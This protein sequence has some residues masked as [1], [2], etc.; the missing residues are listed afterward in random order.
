MQNLTIKAQIRAGFVATLALMVALAL[1]AIYRV[2]IV[3]ANLEQINDVNSVKQRYAINFRGRVHDRAIALRDVVLVQTESELDAAIAEI[4]NLEQIYAE[5]AAPLDKMLAPDQNPTAD[6]LEILDAIKATEAETGP[7]INDVIA[8]HAQGNE[9][10]A[11]RLLLSE[12]RPSFDI[13]L[14]HI[15]QFIDLQEKRNKA[16]ATATRSETGNFTW[17][18]AFLCF[19]AVALG[20]GVIVWATKSVR[21][22][23]AMAEIIASIANGARDVAIP[24]S[25]QKN[26]VGQLARSTLSLRDQLASAERAKEEQVSLIVESVGAGLEELAA[27]DLTSRV[28]AGLDGPFAKLERDF[29]TA[30]SSLEETIATMVTTA[31]NTNTG[32]REVRAASE[33]LSRRTEQQA[34][35]LEE[36]AASMQQVTDLVK[37]TASNADDASEAIGSADLR[38]RDGGTVVKKAVQAMA[39]IEQ[40]SKD[41]T[42]IIDVIDGIAFQTN[43]LALNAGVEAARAGDAGKGFAVV[44]NEVR[45]LAQRS[46]EAARDIKDLISKSSTQVG[47]GVSLVG[48]AGELL[49]TIVD[50]IGSVTAQVDDI[51]EMANTQSSRL[52]TVHSSVNEMDL[53][54]QQNAAMVEETTAAACS[55]SGEAEELK[56]MV[57]RFRTSSVSNGH[58]DI[59]LAA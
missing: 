58:S 8:L 12:A 24:S 28:N 54:T 13:W 29:N 25:N 55:L 26:E 5:S 18:I 40:S 7:L 34:A 6:E 42:Q 1:I 48:Q 41:I 44:A 17:V 46:A 35:R 3:D 4:R 59:S 53:M 52:G 19:G 23:P 39:S 45:A 10:G 36:T 11:M 51:A 22:I 37:R 20:F 57:E 15:N 47:D 27:G 9:A 21:Q 30:V 2:S 50:Q 56:R 32:A 49:Q 43:L 16:I 14:G 33:D 38:A 31:A